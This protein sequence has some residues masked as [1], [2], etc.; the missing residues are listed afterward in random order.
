MRALRSGALPNLIVIGAQKCGTSAMHYYLDLHPEV[1]M[2]SPKEL[3]FFADASEPVA[4]QP[5][6]DPFELSL[7]RRGPRNWS[8]GVDWYAR[9]FDPAKPVRGESSPLYSSPGFPR[10]AERMAAVIPDARLLYLIR[11]PIERMVSQYM[12]RRAGGIE[13]RPIDEAFTAP[14]NIYVGR[15]RFH[16]N[17]VPFVERFGRDRIL[18]LCQEDLLARRR[19]TMRAV[20]AFAGVDSS[21]WSPRM[22]R[23]RNASAGKGLR[24]RLLWTLQSSAAARVGERLPAEVKW[25][26]ER[27]ANRRRRGASRPRLDEGLQTELASQ[28]A[29][30]VEAIAALGGLDLDGYAARLTRPER[31]RRPARPAAPPAPRA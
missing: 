13:T 23:E 16:T 31:P 1:G 19:E 29:G 28:L 17:L 6:I 10:V 7:L 4:G 14:G 26:I 3:N 25:R 5:E 9:R 11:D 2:S 21:F 27:A 12:H 15:S 30:E 22:E 18:V 20:F 24:T 8:R